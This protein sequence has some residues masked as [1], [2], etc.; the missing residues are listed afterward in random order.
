MTRPT[1]PKK[2][3][4]RLQKDWYLNDRLRIYVQRRMKAFDDWLAKRKENR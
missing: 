1:D 4:K 3:V 2:F